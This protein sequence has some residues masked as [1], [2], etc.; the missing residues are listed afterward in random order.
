MLAGV[1]RAPG[2]LSEY[3]DYAIVLYL[4]LFYCSLSN[5]IAEYSELIPAEGAEHSTDP[6][7][8]RHGD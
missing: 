4:F 6:R 2:I 8:G 5:Y 7:D 3:R 1:G